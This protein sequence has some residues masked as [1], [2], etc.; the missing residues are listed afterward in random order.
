M[1]ESIFPKMF[2]M[3]D[4]KSVKF[5][6]RKLFFELINETEPKAL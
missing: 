4:L 2:E 3:W 1:R 5:H 6:L